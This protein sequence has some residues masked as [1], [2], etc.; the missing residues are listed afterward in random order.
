MAFLNSLVSFV[1]SSRLSQIAGYDNSAVEIQYRQLSEL[2]KKGQNTDYGLLY[3]FKSIESPDMFRQRV[4]VVDYDQIRPYVERMQRGEKNLLWPGEI[5]WFAKSSGTTSAKSKFIPVSREALEECHFKGGKD[6][7][8]L[9][10]NN[11]NPES[12]ML[13]G[14]CLTLGGSHQIN[15]FNSDSYFGDLSAILIENSPFWSN[16]IRTPSS[17]I[18]LLEDWDEKLE[19]I[20]KATVNENVT[21]LAGVPSWFLILLRHIMQATGT[22]N[23]HQI[24]PNLELFIHGGINFSPYRQQYND[25]MGRRINYMETYN[26]SEGFFAI[27]DMPGRSDMLLMPDYGIYYEFV[28]LNEVGKPFPVSY[29][30]S[31]VTA[32]VDY[33]V[34]ITTNSGLWRYMIGDTV[35]FTSLYPHRI[36]I[37]G[38]TKHFIN[39]FGEELMIDNAERAMAAACNATGAVMS[40]FTA[41]PVYMDNQTKGRH[42]WLIEFEVNPSSIERFT[43]VLDNALKGLNSDYEAKRNKN[44]TLDMPE[45]LVARPGLFFDWMKSRNKVGGQNKVPRLSNNR[46]YID[47]LLKLN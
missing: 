18:V 41:A 29:G 31:E 7:V 17:D 27:Q 32:G 3:G 21:S 34:V 24:W 12:D 23:L 37:S 36:V 38:R 46:E 14:K 39:A 11:H 9:Y 40:E 28:P 4:P 33:A 43:T 6:V 26:A 22:T 47:E 20:T 10:L 30:L 2:L 25:I 5:R 8:M 45:L 1:N 15:K 42:Q 35:R 19:K 13:T 44:I 16:F